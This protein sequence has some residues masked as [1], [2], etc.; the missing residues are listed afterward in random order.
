ML[1]LTRTSTI[2]HY[3]SYRTHGTEVYGLARLVP[4]GYV[5]T[6]DGSHEHRLVSYKDMDLMLYGQVEIAHAQWA[7]DDAG[8]DLVTP[9][10]R[11][12]TA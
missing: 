3:A 11:T 7:I 10:R 12:R 9:G 6:A 5:F 8:L 1:N 2:V 4:G